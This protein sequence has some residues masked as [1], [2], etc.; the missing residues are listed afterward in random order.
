MILFILSSWLLLHPFHVSVTEIVYNKDVSSIQVS[1]RIFFDDL[2]KGIQEANHNDE[3]NLSIPLDDF[4]QQYL[5]KNTSISVGDRIA[6]LL[7]GEMDNDVIWVY[8]E[9]ENVSIG[10]DIHVK[11]RLLTRIF[12]DQENLVHFKLPSGKTSFRFGKKDQE[13]TV[14]VK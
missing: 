9:L 2:E 12:D 3:Y 11:T 1:Q 8:S 6:T 5:I 13:A 4:A 14:N 10:D 7:G